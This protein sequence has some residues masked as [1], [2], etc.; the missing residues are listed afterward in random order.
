[1]SQIVKTLI[2]FV[3]SFLGLGLTFVLVFPFKCGSSNFHFIIYIYIYSYINYL[4]TTYCFDIGDIIA[5]L[6]GFNL[7]KFDHMSVNRRNFF[8]FLHN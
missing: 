4:I 8:N 3:D 2:L 6:W 5:R 7:L 1:M